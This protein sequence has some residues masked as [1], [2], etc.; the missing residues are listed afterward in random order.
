MDKGGD[1]GGKD[2]A[3]I[4]CGVGRQIERLF[5]LEQLEDFRFGFFKC[6]LHSLEV[7][8]HPITVGIPRRTSCS[9]AT[10]SAGTTTDAPVPIR[11]RATGAR[12][13]VRTSDSDVLF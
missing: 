3:C 13:P 9:I 8:S 11:A 10:E 4:Y 2:T 12:G 7:I 6:V 5:G 1:D